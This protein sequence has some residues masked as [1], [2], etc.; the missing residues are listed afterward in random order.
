M[1]APFRFD[2]L[3]LFP[4]LFEG[5]LGE[6]LIG[7]ACEAGRIAIGLHDW[8]PYAEN[9]HGRVDDAPFGGG[10]GMVLA[11]GPVVRML[12]EVDDRAGRAEGAP[13]PRRVLL[14][15]AGRPF[16][17][18]SAH[19]FAAGS[20]LILLCGR[21]EGFDARVE[22]EVDELLSLGDYVL[23][24]G[25]VAAMVVIEAVAR[26]LPGVIGNVESLGEESHAAGLLEA[27]QY[28][29]PREF[30]GREVPEILLSGDHAKVAAWR[31]EQAITRTAERRPELHAAWLRDNPPPP[32][33]KPRK[34]R[35][36]TRPTENDDA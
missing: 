14:S 31:R 1:D 27:P 13:A 34:P 26:L 23:N 22:D 32:P 4:G 24:G 15:P 10:A 2:V 36:K 12:E 8:R 7:K 3:T 33:K 21:Y 30:R 9:K 19:R 17:Q 28:T 16:D 5:F 25:E 11:P 29:R 35:R 6:S 18:A 20:G